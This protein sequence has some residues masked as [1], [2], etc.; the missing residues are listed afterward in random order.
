[1]TLVGVGVARGIKNVV[2]VV[3]RS[4]ITTVVMI[5]SFLDTLLRNAFPRLV[6][7]GSCVI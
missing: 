1:M 6:L 2:S 5:F 3:T 4:T 7:D